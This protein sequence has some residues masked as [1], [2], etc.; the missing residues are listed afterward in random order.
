MVTVT[1]RPN[2]DG[3]AGKLGEHPGEELHRQRKRHVQ[4]PV[5]R[6]PRSALGIA[7]KKGSLAGT[8]GAQEDITGGGGDRGGWGEA[9]EVTRS[10]LRRP[11]S[12]VTR[13]WAFTQSEMGN[14]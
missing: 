13:I 12:A 10:R 11:L 4:S 5:A 8:S 1:D 14:H 6:T 9:R 3:C 7:A 2:S